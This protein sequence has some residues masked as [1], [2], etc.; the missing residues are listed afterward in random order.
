MP[1][2]AV[3]VR[4]EFDLE[5]RWIE[6]DTDGGACAGADLPESGC[7]PIGLTIA[8]HAGVKAHREL[9]HEC[10]AV[11]AAYIG[12]DDTAIGQHLRDLPDIERQL[13]GARDE[14]HRAGGN[15][16]QRHAGFPGDACRRR[17]RAVAAAGDYRIEI[18]PP[19]GGLQSIPHLVR[20]DHGDFNLVAGSPKVLLDFPAVGVHVRR[21]KS[22]PISIEDGLD[23]QWLLPPS[24]EC[25]QLLR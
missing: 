10:T 1:S 9:V 5:I 16:A 11:G 2:L 12:I 15:D 6:D 17:N 22:P 19:A 7:E 18:A 3:P 13:Q 25:V 20:S 14:I 8:Y 24:C 21:S 23:F 4:V